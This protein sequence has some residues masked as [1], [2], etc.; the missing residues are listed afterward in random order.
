[1]SSETTTCR[2]LRNDRYR[3]ADFRKDDLCEVPTTWVPEMEAIGIVRRYGGARLTS[4][5]PASRPEGFVLVKHL[6]LEG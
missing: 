1:M 3:G 6:P 5:M 2:I 4:A